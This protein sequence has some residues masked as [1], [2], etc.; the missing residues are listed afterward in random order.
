M[1]NTYTQ[2]YIH[3]V[4][5]VQ[6]RKTLIKSEWKK[7]LYK[8]ITGIVQ[9]RGHKL[10][11]IN[12]MPDHIHILVGLN[13]KES[14]SDLVKNIKADSNLY[15]KE[16]GL[17]RNNSFSWQ[18]GYGAFS[19]SRSQLKEIIQYIETQEEH[20]KKMSFMDEY[21]SFLKNYGIDYND[22][23]LFKDLD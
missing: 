19:H 5:A 3:L 22:A 15:I 16:S 13:P 4:F 6:N 7:E 10:I 1:A 12:G 18:E 8:Y 9:T 23:Y 14:I 20:H 17:N 21:L 2:L 11:I